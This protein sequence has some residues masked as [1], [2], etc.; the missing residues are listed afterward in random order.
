MWK[1]FAVLTF[2]LLVLGGGLLYSFDLFEG[3]GAS[4]TQEDFRLEGFQ[5]ARLS[6]SC[7]IVSLRTGCC[8]YQVAINGGMEEEYRNAVQE[9]LEA[10]R[11]SNS[12]ATCDCKVEEKRPV[13]RD[14]LCK[15]VAVNGS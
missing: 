1:A 14:G 8:P 10:L 13:L 3:I 6:E 2:C 11:K 15:A 7:E 12:G 5:R 4:Y 9:K